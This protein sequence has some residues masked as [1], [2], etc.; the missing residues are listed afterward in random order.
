MAGNATVRQVSTTPPRAAQE[1]TLSVFCAGIGAGGQAVAGGLAPSWPGFGWLTNGPERSRGERAQDGVRR[2]PFPQ[3]STGARR[4]HSALD[5]DSELVERCLSGDEAAWESLIK[6]HTR[7][8]YAICYRFTGSEQ[9]A[10]DLTQEVFLRVFRSLKSFRSGE[11]SFSVWLSRLSRNLL[12]DNYRRTKLDRVTDSIEGQLP[13]L[14]EKTA[15]S[16]RTDGL[17]AGREASELLQAALQNNAAKVFTGELNEYIENVR[18]AHEQKI[19]LQNPDTVLN[20]GWDK[21]N[22]AKA[23]ASIKDFEAWMQEHKDELTAL[24]IFYSQP[25]RRRELTYT[26]IKEVL[27]K[28]VTAKPTLAPLHIWRCYEQLEKVTG[29]PKNELIALVSLLRNVTGMDATLTDFSKTVDKNFQDWV[30]KKQAGAMKFN[31][32]QMQWL[33]MIKEY[34]A[35]SYNIEKDDFDLTPFNA[36][37]GLSKMWQ[38][39]G[40]NTEKIIQELNETLAA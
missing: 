25:Y 33:R 19:D 5:G 26:M 12:I 13:M 18:R 30:F 2:E 24:Q 21:D 36:Q 16:A 31:E 23:E 11:G 14:E 32:E 34:I 37:G 17:V 7:R 8:V 38:L 20:A 9:E 40:D 10:Q 6:V 29:Q 4:D 35:S 3:I 27:E 15:M 39:F 1:N 28:L 22:K